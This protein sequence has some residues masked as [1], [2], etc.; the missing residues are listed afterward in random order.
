MD[1]FHP[2]VLKRF[3]KFLYTAEYDEFNVVPDT[4]AKKGKHQ[5]LMSHQLPSVA[6]SSVAA[7]PRTEL[8]GH[9]FPG[10][11]LPGQNLSGRNFLV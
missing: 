1:Y 10:Q 4:S 11:H 2:E 9:N 3:V 7:H 8:P 6:E 5:N